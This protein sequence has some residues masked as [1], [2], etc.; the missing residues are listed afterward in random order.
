MFGELAWRSFFNLIYIKRQCYK[1]M[2]KSIM[3]KVVGEE[4]ETLDI[5][6]FLKGLEEQHKIEIIFCAEVGSRAFGLAGPD[7]D[8]DL[9]FIFLHKQKSVYLQ[10]EGYEKCLSGKSNKYDWQGWDLSKALLLLKKS[11]P[12]LI[13]WICSP[14]I[15]IN[16]TIGNTRFSDEIKKYIPDKEVLLYHYASCSKSTYKAAIKKGSL[17]VKTY[18]FCLRTACMFIWIQE[19]GLADLNLNFEQILQKL[20]PTIG[21]TCFKDITNLI[22]R[23][24][25]GENEKVERRTCLDLLLQKVFDRKF[26]KSKNNISSADYNKLF[27]DFLGVKL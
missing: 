15:Y 11:N 20:E 12:S 8:Y 27:L 17:T 9:R 23:K 7:S 10:L 19:N 21:P 18:L 1:K 2:L 24:H 5:L 26:G 13:E 25:V 14:I 6:D 22:E 4:V 16:S 3:A